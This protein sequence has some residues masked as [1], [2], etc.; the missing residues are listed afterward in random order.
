VSALTPAGKLGLILRIWR[1]Y[2]AFVVGTRRKPLGV[3]I[4]Q[5]QNT[6]PGAPTG[7]S[8][9]H[10]GTLVY[11]VLSVGPLRPRCLHSAL[12]LGALLRG[13]GLDPDIVIGLPS[14]PTDQRAHAWVEI[15][16]RDVGPPPGRGG[17]QELARY[18]AL[19]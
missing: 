12:V 17:H 8:P 14:E 19:G 13:E 7:K 16:G 10:I 11:R 3:M 9:A 5:V 2:A 15:G 1:L 6:P 4:E 18:G